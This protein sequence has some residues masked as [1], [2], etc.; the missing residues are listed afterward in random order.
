MA[1]RTGT[2]KFAARAIDE[3]AFANPAWPKVMFYQERWNLLDLEVFFRAG[4]LS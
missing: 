1:F 4:F 2:S 3:L